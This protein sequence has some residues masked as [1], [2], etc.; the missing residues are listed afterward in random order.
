MRVVLIIVN[1][2]ENLVLFLL[3]YSCIC[4]FLREEYLI[5]LTSGVSYSLFRPKAVSLSILFVSGRILYFISQF[6]RIFQKL[7][8]ILQHQNK[9]NNVSLSTSQKVQ[10][11]LL[12]ILI[13]CKNCLLLFVYVTA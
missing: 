7:C 11:F 8:F 2:L 6:S 4:D 3:I 9:W 5:K 12:L 13:L 10:L 1:I